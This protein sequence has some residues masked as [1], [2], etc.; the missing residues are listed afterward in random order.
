[1]DNHRVGEG[2]CKPADTEITR[3]RAELNTDSRGRSEKTMQP[4]I[5]ERE[6][7]ELLEFDRLNDWSELK[8]GIKDLN[9]LPFFIYSE[10]T[11]FRAT[12]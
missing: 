4:I 3:D 7:N 11:S 6:I 1:M 10:M 8:F 2:W 12:I 5:S 9:D